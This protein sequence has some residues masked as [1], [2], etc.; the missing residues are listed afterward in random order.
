[1]LATLEA[2][3]LQEFRATRTRQSVRVL[4][5][6]LPVSIVSLYAW[7]PLLTLLVIIAGVVTLAS[8]WASVRAV[9]ELA[10]PLSERYAIVDDVL[11][12]QVGE[13]ERARLPRASVRSMMLDRIGFVAAGAGRQIFIPSAAEGFKAIVEVLQTWGP[14]HTR[15]SVMHDV[16]KQAGL[17]GLIRA[18]LTALALVYVVIATGEWVGIVVGELIGLSLAELVIRVVV[19]RSQRRLA[20][21][22]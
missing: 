9:Q 14:V 2:K 19:G 13:H 17:R 10:L 21:A 12:R 11:I 1:M 3:P 15:S 4:G 16:G 8:A 20:A 5:S 18:A 7:D 22:E 6:S